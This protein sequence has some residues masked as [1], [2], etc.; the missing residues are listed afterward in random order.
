MGDVTVRLTENPTET[1]GGDCQ[2][3]CFGGACEYYPSGS[4]SIHVTSTNSA[5]CRVILDRD[6][7]LHENSLLSP[8]WTFAEDLSSVTLELSNKTW[9]LTS[10]KFSID[11]K[12]I[13]T[14]SGTGTIV[15]GTFEVEHLNGNPKFTADSTKYVNASINHVIGHPDVLSLDVEIA[16]CDIAISAE[17]GG[18]FLSLTKA[19]GIV[20]T[21][22]ASVEF[23]NSVID[24]YAPS[25]AWHLVHS[26]FPNSALVLRSVSTKQTTIS[27]IMGGLLSVPSSTEQV[28]LSLLAGSHLHINSKLLVDSEPTSPR[29]ASQITFLGD[30]YLLN[31]HSGATVFPAAF[32]YTLNVYNSVIGGFDL[33]TP[34]VTLQNATL[35]NSPF[36]LLPSPSFMQLEGGTSK[37]LMDDHS[38]PHAPIGSGVTFSSGAIIRIGQNNSELIFSPPS[39][40]SSPIEY[41]GALDITPLTDFVSICKFNPQQLGTNA[42]IKISTCSISL[43][44]GVV[45]I[46]C[47]I[48]GDPNKNP[49]SI[50]LSTNS[51][52][53]VKL[54]LSNF[55]TFVLNVDN[56]PGTEPLIRG[57]SETSHQVFG[58]PKNY[59]IEWH[60]EAA[61]PYSGEKFIIFNSSTSE[62]REEILEAMD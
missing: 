62:V 13:L 12:L 30:S 5:S 53:D 15:K 37:I 54:N 1:W 47:G 40:T 9:D 11:N 61:G 43:P 57:T 33:L 31:E 55:E 19:V 56:R 17:S 4:P 2:Q 45:G 16:N 25:E 38:I 50:S 27:T 35:R 52:Y 41:F 48:V 18:H 58:L 7:D 10:S 23:R 22:P 21:Q 32:G 34:N 46:G 59:R 8:H 39:A 3:D 29:I 42:K 49:L 20:E 14:A 6:G 60:T 28:I 36:V 44:M 24:I 26:E 51:S